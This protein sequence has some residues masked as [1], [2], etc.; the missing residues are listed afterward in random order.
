MPTTA[1]I[2]M[3]ITD[4]KQWLLDYKVGEPYRLPWQLGD[5]SN[6]SIGDGSSAYG[7]QVWL[8]GDGLY[9]SYSNMIRNQV[10]PTDQNYEAE[11]HQHGV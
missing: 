1:E 4:P 7:A 3:M 8:M 6:F 5:Q 10:H 11:P 9:D 2:E